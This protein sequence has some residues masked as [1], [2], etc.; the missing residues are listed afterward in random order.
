MIAIDKVP[1]TAVEIYKMLPEGTRCE[2]IENVIYMSPAPTEKHE[3][4]RFNLGAEIRS[5]VKKFARTY[6]PGPDV[7]FEGLQSAFI[8]DIM[9]ILNTRLDII[10]SGKIYGA[11]DV[12]VEILSADNK[13][14]LVEKKHIYEK[15]G[16]R[17]YF[18]INPETT[19]IIYR[20]LV[21]NVYH[22]EFRSQ[23]VFGSTLLDVTFSFDEYGNKK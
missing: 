23:G 8:P 17:E 9:V 20:R 5:C 21:N 12:I 11:P 10:K 22:Q 14:D 13:R 18:V 16:V 3:L 19:E 6:S 2:V 7:F 15:A 4:L 1:K